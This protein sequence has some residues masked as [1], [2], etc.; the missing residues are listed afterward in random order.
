[1]FIEKNLNPKKKKNAGD[2]AI[3]AIAYVEKRDWLDVYDELSA[4]ARKDYVLMDDNILIKKYLQKYQ[5]IDVKYIN[6]RGEKKRYTVND[7]QEWEGTFLIH[8]SK[9]ITVISNHNNY[10]IWDCG[11]CSAY[12]IWK[13][14]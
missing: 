4:L 6:A 13:I 9:H 8:V 5:K 10:D 14:K 7:I 3:R 11:D 1:M 12:D 2:C